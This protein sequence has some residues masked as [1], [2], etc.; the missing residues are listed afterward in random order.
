MS[1]IFPASVLYVFWLVFFLLEPERTSGSSLK[2][3]EY[4]R[5]MW[6]SYFMRKNL[7]SKWV[8]LNWVMAKSNNRYAN[9][10]QTQL[11][12]VSPERLPNFIALQ[13]RVCFLYLTLVAGFPNKEVNHPAWIQSRKEL[14]FF[15]RMSWAS[16][17]S[18]FPE[19]HVE[20]PCFVN[21]YSR[22]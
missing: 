10:S 13:N 17:S 7:K 12:L 20:K 3:W 16:S 22:S 11:W 18:Q 2:C 9:I 8:L 4:K 15:L 19:G 14:A 5:E 6:I 21:K 1:S